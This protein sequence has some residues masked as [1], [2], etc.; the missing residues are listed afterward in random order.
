MI[1]RATAFSFVLFVSSTKT[2]RNRAA[3]IL[4]MS[5]SVVIIT[6]RG[7]IIARYDVILDQS[8]RA[9]LYHHLSNY[10]E[11][12]YQEIRHDHDSSRTM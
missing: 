12:L 1:I 4:K 2:S 8:K 6:L 9:H 10:T 5:A 11:T 7:V 3:A